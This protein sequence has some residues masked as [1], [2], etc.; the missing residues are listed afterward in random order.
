MPM[1]L[2]QER[3]RL[4][5]PTRTSL[6]SQ[7]HSAKPT[8]S[9]GD[10]TTDRY[11][12]HTDKNSQTSNYY[13]SDPGNLARLT[14]ITYPDGGQTYVGYTDS[15]VPS[16]NPSMTVCKLMNG[17]TSGT[18]SCPISGSGSGTWG[19]ATSVRDG[20]GHTVQT[21]NTSDPE[22]TV[23]GDTIYDGLGQVYKQAQSHKM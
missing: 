1:H 22:G 19:V 23:Y 15:S 2:A 20:M 17:N 8:L 7:T 4:R 5:R 14:Q 6:R 3:P 12:R 18:S 16:S 13:Y 21:Q 10:T 9:L 11:G